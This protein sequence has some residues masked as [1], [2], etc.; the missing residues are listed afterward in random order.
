MIGGGGGERMDGGRGA[1]RM[2]GGLVDDEMFGGPGDDLQVGGHGVDAL[3]GGD[4]DDWMRGDTNRDIHYGDAG[5][6]TISYATATPPGPGGIEGVNVNLPAEEGEEDDPLLVIGNYKPEEDVFSTESVVG[7]NYDDVLTGT[8]Q[9]T[10]R[11][12]GGAEL[13][14][15]FLAQD[16]GSGPAPNVS[17]DILAIDPGLLIHGG[18]GAQGD[19]LSLSVTPEAYVVTSNLPLSAGDGCANS[20]AVVVACGKPA[21]TLG[22]ATVYGGDG[23]DQLNIADGFPEHA[24]IVLDGGPGS[25][26]DQ[27]LFGRRHPAGG[28]RRRGR[29]RR[30]RGQR[31]ALLGPRRRPARWRRR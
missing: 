28:A 8:N 15:G 3:H 22:Y 30:P 23:P 6:D 7:S 14:S 9:G 21:T 10:A 24:V 20:S 19:L 17:L 11:G 29:P 1:D 5:H 12:L 4:G 31:R 26:V 13:C 25:D 18:P 16:C 27:G 2:Y